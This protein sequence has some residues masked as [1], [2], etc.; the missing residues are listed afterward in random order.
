MPSEM[1]SGSDKVGE[2]RK[3]LELQNESILYQHL[4]IEVTGGIDLKV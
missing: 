4:L 1:I 2:I 3:E